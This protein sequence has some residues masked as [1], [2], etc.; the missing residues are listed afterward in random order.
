[1]VEFTIFL[2]VSPKKPAPQIF[3]LIRKCIFSIFVLLIYTKHTL[4]QRKFGGL[5]I[6]VVSN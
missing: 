2:F 1:M 6:R 5:S 3:M 4:S